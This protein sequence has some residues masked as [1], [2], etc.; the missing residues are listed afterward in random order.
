MS[1]ILFVDDTMILYD[2]NHDQLSYLSWV[3][4]WFETISGLKLIWIRVR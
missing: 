1:H 4:M 2:A 3:F